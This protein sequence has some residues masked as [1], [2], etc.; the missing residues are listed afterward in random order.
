MWVTLAVLCGGVAARTLAQPVHPTATTVWDGVYSTA[1]AERG[2]FVY[3]RYCQRCHGADLSGPGVMGGGI[4]GQSPAPALA[5]SEFNY[6]WHELT[7]SELAQR[8][9]SMPPGNPAALSR[10][11]ATDVLAYMLSR[12]GFPSGDREL[13]VGLPE[14]SMIAFLATRP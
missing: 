1:Q 11:D 7:I 3:T 13:P 5:G 8:V 4:P 14:L 9:R 2:G 12:G 6:R 10:L